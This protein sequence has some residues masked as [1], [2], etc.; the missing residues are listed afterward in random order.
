MLRTYHYKL[1][2]TIISLHLLYTKIHNN[3]NYIQSEFKTKAFEFINYFEKRLKEYDKI[4]Y[5]K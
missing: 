5:N 1:T 2:A 4:F 3:Y